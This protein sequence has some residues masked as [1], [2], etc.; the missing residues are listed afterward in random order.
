VDTKTP[1]LISTSSAGPLG[2]LHLPR[3]W[4]KILLH[5]AGRLPEG[6]RHGVGGF[7]EF[8]CTSI[9]LDRDPFIT[10]VEGRQPSYLETEAYVREHAT[11][12]NAQS[13]EAFNRAV[14]T[15]DMPAEMQGPRCNE[16]GIPL[17]EITRAIPLNDLDDWAAFHRS[18]RANGV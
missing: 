4:Q 2:L 3:L 12:L 9:G 8:L 11:N 16:L 10:F 1:P 6:Y 14:T 17:G 13:I 18:L 5:A 15:R 7:D